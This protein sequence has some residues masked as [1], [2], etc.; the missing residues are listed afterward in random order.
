M[1]LR[2][3]K[4]EYAAIYVFLNGT[5][6]SEIGWLCTAGKVCLEK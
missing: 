6:S 3:G 5:D 2:K 4:S 1:R